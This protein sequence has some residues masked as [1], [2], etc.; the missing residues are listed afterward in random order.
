MGYIGNSL[1]FAVAT[2]TGAETIR[3]SKGEI[4][5]EADLRQDLPG[6]RGTKIHKRDQ[7][8]RKDFR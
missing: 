3:R 2:S 5:K 8:K 1:T 4:L 6:E 7:Q